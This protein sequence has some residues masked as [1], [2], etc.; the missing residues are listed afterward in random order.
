[1]EYDTLKVINPGGLHARSARTLVELAEDYESRII[2]KHEGV[3][4]DAASIMEVM[5]LAASPGSEI[6]V[7]VDG[8]DETEALEELRTFFDEGFYEDESNV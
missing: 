5:M 2:L 1:M 6:N 7:E 4:A 3:E 8:P